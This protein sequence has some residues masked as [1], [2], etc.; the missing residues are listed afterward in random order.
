MHLITSPASPW[1]SLAALL[2]LFP[3]TSIS[4]SQRS[5]L[6]PPSGGAHTSVPSLKS[7]EQISVGIHCVKI[8]AGQWSLS[9]SSSHPFYLKQNASSVQSVMNYFFGFGLTTYVRSVE[10]PS[11]INSWVKE[12]CVLIPYVLCMSSIASM[13]LQLCLEPS[14]CLVCPPY[15]SLTVCCDSQDNAAFKNMLLRF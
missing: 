9:D 11:S 12:L 14:V 8:K 13:M 5:H 7:L 6:S 3:T 1:N 15:F 2:S 10:N 4:C